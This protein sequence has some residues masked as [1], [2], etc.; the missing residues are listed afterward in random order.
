MRMPKSQT[1]AKFTLFLE[2]MD[3]IVHIDEIAM[4]EI[5][6]VL[7][8]SLPE[9]LDRPNSRKESKEMNS[10]NEDFI[11][12]NNCTK[13][14][15]DCSNDTIINNSNGSAIDTIINDSQPLCS[16]VI[17]LD[18]IRYYVEGVLLV[19]LC[20]FGFFGKQEHSSWNIS[21]LT[22]YIVFPAHFKSF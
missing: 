6:P 14:V 18:C 11:V 16:A 22:R 12:F 3:S 13:T 9:I 7:N 21:K 19:P 5:L 1:M 10:D 17:S 2:N 4:E 20:I 8:L 15:E